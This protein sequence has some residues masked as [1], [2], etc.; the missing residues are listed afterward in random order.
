[1]PDGLVSTFVPLRLNFEAA[2][3]NGRFYIYSIWNRK[4][5]KYYIGISRNPPR[6]INEQL[7]SKAELKDDYAQEAQADQTRMPEDRVFECGLLNA[8][9]YESPLIGCIVEVLYMVDLERSGRNIYNRNK[10]GGHPELKDKRLAFEAVIK[11]IDPCLM[12]H[13]TDQEML[14][15]E[16]HIHEIRDYGAKTGYTGIFD[17][18]FIGALEKA[19]DDYTQRRKE[20]GFGRKPL[21]TR[22]A[23]ADEYVRLKGANDNDP[24]GP[25]LTTQH[26]TP[27]ALPAPDKT[28]SR[29]RYE[30]SSVGI[31]EKEGPEP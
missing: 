4:K 5:D 1:M 23:F 16:K 8:E 9:G 30:D 25:R 2:Q 14:A 28:G 11:I 7:R 6:R 17:H 13:P 27:L 10:F 12:G 24:L 3:E 29:I 21:S 19:W 31:A 26:K 15:L 22:I 20:A 18:E